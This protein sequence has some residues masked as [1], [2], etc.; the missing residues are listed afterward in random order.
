ME[1]E[2]IKKL[3]LLG[4]AGED[5]VLATVTRAT[6]STPRNPGA[7]ML[8]LKDG[9]VYGTIG[10]GLGE[11]EVIREAFSVFNNKTSKKYCVN[12]TNDIAAGEGMVCGGEMEVFLDF[13]NSGDYG[14]RQVL[15]A[16]LDSRER[17]ENPLLVTVTGIDN[18]KNELLGRKMV[19]LPAKGE[20][21][22]LGY[23]EATEQARILAGRFQTARKPGL[24]TLA[25]AGRRDIID[26]LEL[27][28]ET[29]FSTP[30]ILILGG[31]HIAVPLVKMSSILGYHTVVVDDRPSFADTNRFPE[32]GQV[33]CADFRDFL[34]NFKAGEETF[35]II[36]TRG[37]MHD[38]ECLREVINQP[39]AYIGMI[40]SRRKIKMIMSQLEKEGVSRERLSEVYSPIGLDI[41]AETPEEIALSIMAE[42]VGVWRGG[43]LM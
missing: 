21:G 26:K 24:V 23:A 31:G 40:G 19:F 4:E 30:Q 5:A 2:L 9:R 12:M 34:K 11:A 14:T 43:N 18:D 10:G 25:A 17:N 27:F 1:T 6:G 41:G 33:I 20:T 7:K 42:I 28:F 29:G 37:H 38:L 15:A 22:D 3:L 13:V 16:Y 39:A 32:A 36:V 8:I 35:I